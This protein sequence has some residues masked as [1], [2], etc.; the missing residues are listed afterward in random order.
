M[1]MAESD[2]VDGDNGGDSGDCKNKMVKRSPRSK[3]SNKALAYLTANTRRTFT[4]LRQAFTK[5][6]ILRH[7]DPK[8]HIWIKTDAS[9]YVIGSVLS[10]L[11]NSGQWQPMTYYSQ[12]MILAKTRYKTYDDELLAIVEAFKTWQYYLEDC[13]YQMLVFTN[14]NNLCCFM[15]M[16][17]LSFCQVGWA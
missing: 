3:N 10:Q 15:E 9:G 7:F 16:K 4:Q 17:S 11:P 5:A 14:Y 6:L 12:K 8:C 2:E 1:Y 13:K